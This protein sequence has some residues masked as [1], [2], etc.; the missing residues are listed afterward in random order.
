VTK[1]PSG[2]SSLQ[3]PQLLGEVGRLH[4][5]LGS[6]ANLGVDAIEATDAGEPTPKELPPP[7]QLA[8]REQPAA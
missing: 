1:L 3:L 2:A 8:D 5:A 7:Q 4:E 6:V